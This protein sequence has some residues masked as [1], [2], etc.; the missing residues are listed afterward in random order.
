ML[1]ERHWRVKVTDFNLSRM[2]QTSSPGSSIASLLA[3]NPRWLAPEVGLAHL[4]SPHSS[5]RLSKA[6]RSSSL[7]VRR[8]QQTKTLVLLPLIRTY[9]WDSSILVY[10]CFIAVLHRFH[11]L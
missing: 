3:N 8:L 9:L 2:V 6:A 4:L 1:V 7:N 11:S 10:S 5:T